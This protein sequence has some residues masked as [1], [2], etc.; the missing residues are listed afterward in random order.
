M[1]KKIRNI[2]LG[3]FILIII[4]SFTGC[5]L[6]YSAFDRVVDVTGVSIDQN[7][8][9]LEEGETVQLSA[10]ITPENATNKDVTWESNDTDVAT[11]DENGL[12]TAVAAGTA[13]IT[14]MTDAGGFEDTVE[15]TVTEAGDDDTENSSISIEDSNL[16]QAIRDEVNKPTDELTED[17]VAEITEL[18]AMNMEIQSLE[19]IQHLKSLVWLQLAENNIED[20][21]PLENLT[22][23]ESLFL[24]KNEIDDISPLENLTKL[25]ALFLQ[26]N[27][28]SDLSPLEHLDNLEELLLWDNNFSQSHLNYLSDL[29][30]LKTLS[31]PDNNISDIS[32]LENLINLESLTIAGNQINDISYLSDMSELTYLRL[33]RNSID[34]LGVLENLN[35]IETLWF[36]DNNISN[37]SPLENLTNLEV[38]F[39]DFNNISDLPE[40]DTDMLQYF[41]NLRELSIRGN[42]F[43][44]IEGVQHLTNLEYFNFA[45]N[46]VDDISPL[47]ENGGLA[48]GGYVD[49]TYNYLDLADGSDD[50]DDIQALIDR[51][52]EVIYEPQREIIEYSD[53][54]DNTELN[55]RWSVYQNGCD[56][57][58]EDSE[59]K[60]QGTTERS[61]W[62]DGNGIVTY[63]FIPEGSFEVSVDF[64]VHQY[65]GD[66]P[67]LV[68]L[69]AH[70]DMGDTVGLFFADGYGYRVQTWEPS[71]VSNW[72]AAFGDEASTFHTMKLIYDSSSHSLTGYVDDT[73]VGSLDIEINGNISF[74]VS[75]AT[76]KAGTQIDLRFDNFSALQ[77]L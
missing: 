30:N 14:V 54:F 69:Q 46:N 23:L 36:F 25:R 39:M 35:K 48:N 38:L 21:T 5:E 16:E 26:N 66:S 59:L 9:S 18:D 34:D 13:V 51:G 57:F 22:D 37:I 53:N 73:E 70:S 28:I 40:E 20:I 60:I 6:F 58:V 43:T 12:V 50:M 72:L 19:G 7:D 62:G 64:R 52:I 31:I 47:I 67:R 24:W 44:S 41:N 2:G 8:Q 4:I 65:D 1:I 11:V 45:R 33:D 74:S 63:R 56:I 10:T 15:I 71:Q 49:M 32:P 76:D 29:S 42:S 68:Y 3:F 17:D 61:G 77:I 27:N 55:P 75:A